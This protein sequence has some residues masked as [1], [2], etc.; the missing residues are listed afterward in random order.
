MYILLFTFINYAYIMNHTTWNDV[1][2]KDIGKYVTTRLLYIV[3]NAI[4]CMY[5]LWIILLGNGLIIIFNLS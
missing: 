3:G 1:H 2:D 4:F 5:E